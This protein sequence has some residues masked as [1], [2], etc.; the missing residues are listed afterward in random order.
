MNELRRREKAFRML[1]PTSNALAPCN[2][3]LIATRKLQ[4]HLLEEFILPV[5][6]STC[7]SVRTRRAG[8]RRNTYSF[9]VSGTD[10]SNHAQFARRRLIY[11]SGCR[12]RSIP[13][14]ES[15]VRRMT[16]LPVFIRVDL[17]D[18][19]LCSV[20]SGNGCV[21][22]ALC[23][24]DIHVER[25]NTHLYERCLR[26]SVLDIPAESAKTMIVPP[27]S[28][29]TPITGRQILRLMA[30]EPRHRRNLFD[31]DQRAASAP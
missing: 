14:D 5:R 2:V 29:F 19:G 22:E 11:V 20:L 16:T 26:G 31:L 17:I 7:R 4:R 3:L 23:S 9:T 24:R 1:G 30:Q 8:W 18:V 15:F 28:T 25:S 6:T 21:N 12:N 10:C 27:R 13:E